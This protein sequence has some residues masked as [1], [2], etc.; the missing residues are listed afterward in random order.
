MKKWFITFVIINASLQV[1]AQSSVN[2]S[3][4]P[5]FPLGKFAPQEEFSRDDAFASL[6][7]FITV[8]YHQQKNSKFGFNAALHVQRNPLSY[9][10]FEQGL[11]KMDVGTIIFSPG[12]PP[13]TVPESNFPNWSSKNATWVINALLLGTHTIIHPATSKTSVRFEI[14]AGPCFV[15]APELEASSFSPDS[16][17]HFFQS[18]DSEFGIIFSAGVFLRKQINKKTFFAGVSF[19]QTAN[20]TFND[21][22]TIIT[23]THGRYATP[24]YTVSQQTNTTDIKRSLS[25]LNI[26]AGISIPIR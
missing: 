1:V 12:G 16:S 10:K 20:M 4:G 17:A 15:Y 9:K 26:H 21:T 19:M 5:S 18:K 6:G 8:S 24:G 22:K 25:T 7:Q 11:S 23:T 3:I 13:P 2:F 14:S